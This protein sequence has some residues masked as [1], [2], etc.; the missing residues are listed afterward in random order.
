MVA[1][2]IPDGIEVKKLLGPAKAPLTFLCP[3]FFDLKNPGRDAVLIKEPTAFLDV[4]GLHG[5]LNTP[6]FCGG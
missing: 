3:A 6:L 1:Q 5:S 2:D 4:Q